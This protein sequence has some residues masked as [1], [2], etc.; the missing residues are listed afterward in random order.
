MICASGVVTTPC[1]EVRVV[2]GLSA[3]IAT[4]CPT[5]A[6]SRVDF[7]AFGRPT[8]ETNPDL[9]ELLMRNFRG[10]AQPYLLHAQ[11]VTSHHFHLHAVSFYRFSRLGH[12][13]KPFAHHASHRRRLDV[14]QTVKRVHE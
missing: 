2:C 10:L 5:S 11:I 12:S 13:A 9:N 8:M 1:M 4:F 7:P 3:T 6:F 14:L